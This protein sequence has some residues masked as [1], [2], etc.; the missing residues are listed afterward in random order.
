MENKTNSTYRTTA[1]ISPPDYM[2]P[3]RAEFTKAAL[4]GL[5]ANHV[6]VEAKT[7]LALKE[8]GKDFDSAAA[9]LKRELAEDAVEIA[10]AVI[11]QLRKH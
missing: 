2:D 6:W 7:Q 11:E 5:L 4:Q 9:W 8:C 10:D 1:I 3:V